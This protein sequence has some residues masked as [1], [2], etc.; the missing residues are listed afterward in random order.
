VVENGHKVVVKLFL[1]WGSI[2]PNSKNKCGAIPL[3][4]AAECGYKAVV[5]LL[6]TWDNVCF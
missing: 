2:N 1:V 5:G 4:L 3:L 6:L